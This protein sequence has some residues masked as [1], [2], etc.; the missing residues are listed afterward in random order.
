M[1]DDIMAYQPQGYLLAPAA[2]LNAV[3]AVYQ[4][5]KDF[6]EKVQIGRASCRERV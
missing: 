5:K 6:I 2:A 1:N 3:L 4:A